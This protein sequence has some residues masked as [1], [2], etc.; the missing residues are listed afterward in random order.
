LVEYAVGAP[1]QQSQYYVG[2]SVSLPGAEAI[3]AKVTLPDQRTVE[4][5][6]GPFQETGLPGIYYVSQ[7]TAEWQ[8]AVNLDPAETRT[9]PLADDELESL[10]VPMRGV[11]AVVGA[12]PGREPQQR[13]AELESQQ[14][15]W[16]WLILGALIVL[17]LESWVAGRLTRRR[18]EAEVG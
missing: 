7:G 15:L 6:A 11:T 8:F 9:A 17:G 18:V 1:V 13:A 5:V 12:A 16:R 4:V 14:K 2:D 3:P 10:G